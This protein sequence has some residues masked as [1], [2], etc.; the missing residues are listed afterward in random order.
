MGQAGV[1]KSTLA[2][3][4]IGKDKDC[5]DGDYNCFGTPAYAGL[6]IY[7]RELEAKEGKFIG[8]PNRPVSLIDTPGF[9]YGRLDNEKKTAIDNM[10]NRLMDDIKWV[11][12][13][14]IAI[15][16]QQDRLDDR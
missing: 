15:N 14:I 3:V 5:P 9:G 4:L 16:E 2:N 6:T 10:L 8:D 13:F 7:T 12:V 11:H 1:G